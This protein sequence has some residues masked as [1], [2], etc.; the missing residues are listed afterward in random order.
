MSLM[1]EI[2]LPLFFLCILLALLIGGGCALWCSLPDTRRETLQQALLRVRGKQASGDSRPP[3]YAVY[4]DGH[5]L[6]ASGQEDVQ[7]FLW[8][9]MGVASRQVL[10]SMA[11][12]QPATLVFTCGTESVVIE[13]HLA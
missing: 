9:A 13:V 1:L 8:T 6:Y 5:L 3:I 4:V 2:I 7:M 12:A 10:R 11:D